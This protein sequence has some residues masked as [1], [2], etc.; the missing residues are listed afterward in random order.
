MDAED[1]TEEDDG[2]EWQYVLNPNNA[3][4]VIVSASAESAAE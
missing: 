1:P 3:T 4:E 2:K